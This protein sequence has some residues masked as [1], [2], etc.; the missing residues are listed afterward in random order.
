MATGCI[1]DSHAALDADTKA[2]FFNHI[3]LN[4]NSRRVSLADRK[5]M[6]EWL[7]SCGK[8]PSNQKEF[9]R[10][11]YVKRTF[12]WDEVTKELWAVDE[13]NNGKRLVIT[14]ESIPDVVETVHVQNHHQGW[15]ATWK[16]VRFRYYGILRA[17]LIFLRKRCQVCTLDPKKQPKQARSSHTT[18]LTA[19][20]REATE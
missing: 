8:R 19:N 13:S 12:S 20:S 2:Q 14:E 6:I 10:R 11:N 18:A 5:A 7:T 9:S 15:D 1:S 16:E 3:S 4:P 17:D